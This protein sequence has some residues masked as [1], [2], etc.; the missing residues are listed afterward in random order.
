MFHEFLTF[1]RSTEIL[2]GAGRRA[3]GALINKV[4]PLKDMGFL[5]FKKLVESNINPIVEY[6]A[7]V[8]GYQKAE[9][10]DQLILRSLR[11]FLGVLRIPSWV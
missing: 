7:V 6:G 4:K 3:L 10:I 1:S 2:A 5:T 11:F 8:W 9:K